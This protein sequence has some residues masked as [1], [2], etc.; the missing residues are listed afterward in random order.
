MAKEQ[1]EYVKLASQV[2]KQYKGL[3]MYVDALSNVV[4]KINYM[5]KED[6]AK[7]GISLGAGINGEA[8]WAYANKQAEQSLA[9]VNFDPKDP[10]FKANYAE[11]KAIVKQFANTPDLVEALLGTYLRTGTSYIDEKAVLSLQTVKT[12]VSKPALYLVSKAAGVEDESKKQIDDV[13]EPSDVAP[14]IGQIA[15]QLREKVFRNVGTS[16]IGGLEKK[17]QEELALV[18]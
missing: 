10:R 1:P 5:S 18:A 11:I 8:V 14:V 13:K 15:P 3:K 17:V 6:L 7:E 16:T 4:R 12:D 2:V 9:G